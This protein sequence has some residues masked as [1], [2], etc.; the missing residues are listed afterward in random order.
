MMMYKYRGLATTC[1]NHHILVKDPTLG[2]L[3]LYNLITG[4]MNVNELNY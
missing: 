1:W 4:A 3:T 2:V